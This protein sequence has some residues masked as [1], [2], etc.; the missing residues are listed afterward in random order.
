MADTRGAGVCPCRFKVKSARVLG[1][2]RSLH[3]CSCPE[4]GAL[5]AMQD[6]RRDHALKVTGGGTGLVGY[7]A[8]VPFPI[9]GPGGWSRTHKVH[10]LPAATTRNPSSRLLERHQIAQLAISAE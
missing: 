9:L 1:D 3:L 7:A 6:R 8:A 10:S 2:Y 5:F 4:T